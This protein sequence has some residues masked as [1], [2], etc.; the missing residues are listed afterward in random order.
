M[1]EHP[2]KNIPPYR[3]RPQLSDGGIPPRYGSEEENEISSTDKQVGKTG[4]REINLP[5]SGIRKP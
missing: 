5:R 4:Y 2:I 3:L 1:G